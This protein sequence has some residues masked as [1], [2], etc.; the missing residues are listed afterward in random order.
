PLADAAHDVAA[1]HLA[2]LDGGAALVQLAADVDRRADFRQG[3]DDPERLA[4]IGPALQE[5]GVDVT[6]GALRRADLQPAAGQFFE[7]F[8]PVALAQAVGR[9]EA[10]VEAGAGADLGLRLDDG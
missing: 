5:A 2:A 3:V 4:G 9:I 10:G 7:H 6:V 8:H 1:L